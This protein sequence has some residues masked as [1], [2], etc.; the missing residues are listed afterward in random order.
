[1]RS[2]IQL[3]LIQYLLRSLQSQIYFL[4]RCFS[5]LLVE[6]SEYYHS[7]AARR[8]VERAKY[9]VFAPHAYLPQG[10]LQMPDVRPA[11]CLQT[12]LSDQLGDPH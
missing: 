11:N 7:F 2:T 12:E 9:S 3:L 5:G 8:N 10:V 4:S 6:D 1:M